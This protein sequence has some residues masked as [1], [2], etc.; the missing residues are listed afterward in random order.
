MQYLARHP[1]YCIMAE[2]PGAQRM[3]YSEAQATSPSPLALLAAMQQFLHLSL[4]FYDVLMQSWGRQ[5][6]REGT[7]MAT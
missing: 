2:A 6:G 3:A 5:K 7:G 1:E 4:A